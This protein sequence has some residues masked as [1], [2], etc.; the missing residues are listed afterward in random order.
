MALACDEFF[1]ARAKVYERPTGARSWARGVSLGALAALPLLRFPALYIASP[2]R[3]VLYLLKFG[4]L[5]LVLLPIICI[6]LILD[7]FFNTKRGVL[8]LKKHTRRQI[9]L[10]PIFFCACFARKLARKRPK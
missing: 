7:M 2:D 5:A 6:Y 10:A 3:A 8:E 4:D 9:Y 1:G